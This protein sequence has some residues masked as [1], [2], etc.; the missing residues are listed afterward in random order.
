MTTDFS[1]KVIILDDLMQQYGW[2]MS[3]PD[4]QYSTTAAGDAG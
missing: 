2:T 1:S 3:G 4:G